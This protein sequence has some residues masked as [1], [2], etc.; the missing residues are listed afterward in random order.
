[1][2]Q[3]P[4][5]SLVRRALTATALFFLGAT[6]PSVA[7]AQQPQSCGKGVTLRLNAGVAAQ[8]GLLELTLNSTAPI[9]DLT[10]TWAGNPLPFWAVAGDRVHHALVG[11]DLERAPGKYDL[12]VSGQAPG[13]DPFECKAVVTV[14]EGHFTIES[15]KVADQFVNPDPEESARG[16]KDSAQ[17]HEIYAHPTAERLWTGKFRTPLDGITTGHNFGKR[18]V[19]N[20]EKRSPHTGLDMPAKTGTPIHASQRGRVMLA[21]DLY[22]SGNTVILDHGLGVYTFYCHMSAIKVAVGDMVNMGTIIGLVGATGR[23]T[24]PHLHWS[25]NVNGARVNPLQIVAL[26]VH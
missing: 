14:K 25:L 12:A 17:I 21:D 11:I 3:R 8:G 4:I 26:G 2:K 13:S 9:A 10:G 23:V 16:E 15:L 22:F 18:R 20:G 5:Q 6:F 1:M 7:R 24:G 19:L